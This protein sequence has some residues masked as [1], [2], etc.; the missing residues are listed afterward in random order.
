MM[1]SPISSNSANRS[2]NGAIVPVRPAFRA[3]NNA[4]SA[5]D[6]RSAGDSAPASGAAR[7]D[8]RG[9]DGSFSRYAEMAGRPQ[10]PLVAHLIATR[11]GLP[12]T[13]NLRRASAGE[14]EF[15]YRQAEDLRPKAASSRRLSI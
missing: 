12:Q 5:D 14:A 7:K 11:M 8:T 1:M 6:P 10:A 9:G 3:R 13:R 4:H 2:R 15:A